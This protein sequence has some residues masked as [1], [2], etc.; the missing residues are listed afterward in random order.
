MTAG[1]ISSKIELGQCQK[2]KAYI[3]NC[4][5][6]GMNA[7]IDPVALRETADVRQALI[8]GRSLYHVQM[9][10][11]KPN[12]AFNVIGSQV[13]KSIEHGSPLWAQHPC[14]AAGTVR[15]SKVEAP[16]EGPQQAP[17]TPG[18]LRDGFRPVRARVSGSQGHTA[19]QSMADYWGVSQRPARPAI[20]RPSRCAIC[21]G[22]LT[23]KEKGATVIEY[24]GRIIWGMHD[25]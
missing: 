13:G 22:L 21:R 24:N 8:T 23:G 12:K 5:V 17:V 2:C 1:P 11:G 19:A 14:M 10:G 25:H 3:F 18:G 4:V 15:A 16:P 7:A 9:L 6:A 20:L